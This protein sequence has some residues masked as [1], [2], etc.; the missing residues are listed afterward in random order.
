VFLAKEKMFAPRTAGTQYRSR[1]SVG[2]KTK[3]VAPGTKPGPRWCPAGITP[4]QKRWLQ[5]LRA[6]EIQEEIADR[7][8][9]VWFNKHMRVVPPKM[10]WKKKRITTEENRN[11]DGTIAAQ[12]V[13]NNSDAPTD[14]DVD[15]GG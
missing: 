7:N 3:S 12:N 13:K 8:D 14:M 10:T 4:T 9:D 11:A 2:N 6:S 15:Q 1:N 5:R